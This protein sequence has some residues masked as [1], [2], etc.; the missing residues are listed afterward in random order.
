MTRWISNTLNTDLYRARDEFWWKPRI[1]SL[2]KLGYSAR[3]MR[4]VSKRLIGHHVTHDIITR[5]WENG[6]RL[7]GSGLFKYL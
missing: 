3:Q 5:V 1:I 7:Y 4:E 2:F 6:Y